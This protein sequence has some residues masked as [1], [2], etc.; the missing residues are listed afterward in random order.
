MTRP[1]TLAA[2]LATVVTLSFTS[3]AA[4]GS[5]SSKNWKPEISLPPVIQPRPPFVPPVVCPKPPIVITP[6]VVCP[7]RPPIV[8]TPPVV[9]PK[10]P[11]VLPPPVVY[12]KP[13]IVITPPPVCPTPTITPVTCHRPPVCL[14]WIF[15]MTVQI[16]NTQYGP[17]IQIFSVEPGGPAQL[18]GL[19]PGDVIFSSNGTPLAGARTNQEAVQLLQSTVQ[20]SNP[21]A[22]DPVSGI[23]APTATFSLASTTT[24]Q[25]Q[26]Y[27][28][29]QVGI[30]QLIVLDSYNRSITQLTVY[31]Q[32]V[33]DTP[34]A[35]L[36]V[37]AQSA[38]ATGLPVAPTQTVP[39]HSAPAA[40][41]APTAVAP[42]AT[43]MTR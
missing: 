36:G 3:H 21:A 14:H 35:T 32:A 8:I 17:G 24:A 23:G 15:G 9:C 12:P 34:T 26:T 31:P 33:S 5:C 30:A 11:V 7:P 37:P 41:A 25:T 16:I 42:T 6:P 39:T 28:A 4:A 18:A 1:A 29:A 38:P 20:A 40:T 22:G 10:P 2:L 13:P 43:F 19:K 27:R